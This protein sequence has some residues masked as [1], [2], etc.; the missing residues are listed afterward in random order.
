[1]AEAGTSLVAGGGLAWPNNET[2]PRPVKTNTVRVN[3]ALRLMGAANANGS[4][5]KRIISEAKLTNPATRS[6]TFDFWQVREKLQA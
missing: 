1:M 5:D 6:S 2:A 4:C 3:F